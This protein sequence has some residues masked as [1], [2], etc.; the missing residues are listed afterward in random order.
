MGSPFLS[1]EV[2]NQLDPTSARVP[3]RARLR[4]LRWIIPAAVAGL[5]ALAALAS[6]LLIHKISITQTTATGTDRSCTETATVSN[7]GWFDERIDAVTFHLT[8]SGLRIVRPLPTT[9]PSGASATMTLH[10]AGPYCAKLFSFDPT[11]HRSETSSA[12]VIQLTLHRWWG[13]SSYSLPVVAN[14]GPSGFTI[15][16]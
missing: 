3:T 15:N 1:D 5:L 2:W 10:F 8:G 13:E 9:I 4:A 14:Q 16:W 12:P 7:N 6:G 11:Q